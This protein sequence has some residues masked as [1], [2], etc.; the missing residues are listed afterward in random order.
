MKKYP[1]LFFPLTLIAAGVLWLLVQMGNIPTENLW[2]LTHIW[3]FVLIV[4]GLGLIL[5]SVWHD[6]A[7]MVVTT[8]V[9][10]GAFLA[11]LF[12]PQLGWND[13]PVHWNMGDDF[14]GSIPGSKTIKSETRELESFNT[15]DLSY[16]ADVV[17]VQGKSESIEFEA[18]DNLLPQLE[19][20][21]SGSTLV[22]TNNESS[23]SKRV[24]PSQPVK[25]TITVKELREVEFSTAGKLRIEGLQGESLVI[26]LNGAG[27]VDLVGVKVDTLD[28]NLDGA[29]NIT[30]NGTAKQLNVEID[31]FGNFNGKD[32]KSDS[33]DVTIN[34]AGNITLRV[35]QTLEASVN[36][37]GSVNYYGSPNVDK[38]VNGAGSVKQAGE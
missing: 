32:L 18:D 8:L 31:G 33:A 30:A 12:A 28:C 36:G 3:P 15:V 35:E 38:N 23:Q 17:I 22:I 4:L 20:Q 9:V 29:G 6:G 10:A 14:S 13:V 7:G 26:D 5:R 16:P 34:G 25:I 19:A 11:V 21:V 24:R 27:D 1:S 2:A 37:A